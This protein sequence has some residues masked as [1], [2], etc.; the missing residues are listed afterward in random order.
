MITWHCTRRFIKILGV[1]PEVS[2][3]PPT[4][5]L[6]DWYA[7]YIQTAAGNLFVFSNEKTFVSVAIPESE[8]SEI[9]MLFTVRVGNLLGMLGI[10]F[11]NID[12]EMRRIPPIQ[13][14]H[15]HDRRQLGHL[16]SIVYHY[17]AVAE[18]PQ[19]TGR[20]SLSDAELAVSRMPHLGSFK[21]FPDKELFNLF[22][23]ERN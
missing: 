23:V 4:S 3:R 21:S 15:A 8:M 6:G 14:A 10:P 9:E 11:P 22:G 2:T 18:R 20:L 17:Q 16:Q 19:S 7:N 1:K 13:Y 12:A 5:K